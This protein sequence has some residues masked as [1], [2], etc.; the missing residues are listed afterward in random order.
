MPP[1]KSARSKKVRKIVGRRWLCRYEV[2]LKDKD[3]AKVVDCIAC[4]VVCVM[5]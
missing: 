4:G 5:D 1:A 2:R 3:Q